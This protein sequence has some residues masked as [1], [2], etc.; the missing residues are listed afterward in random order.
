MPG[1]IAYPATAV[2]YPVMAGAVASSIR[3][4]TQYFFDRLV[5]QPSP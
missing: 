2:R 1:T 5:D 3:I 4:R